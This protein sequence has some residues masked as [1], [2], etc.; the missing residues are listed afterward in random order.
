MTFPW[1]CSSIGQS[2]ALSRRKLRVRVP[3]VPMDTNPKNINWLFLFLFKV[4][5]GSDKERKRNFRLHQ[6]VLFL[7]GMDKRSS[8][9]ILFFSRRWI[10]FI[11]QILLFVILIRFDIIQIKFI[12]LNFVRKISHFYGIKSRSIY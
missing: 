4:R 12:P 11:A 5:K 6:K 9:V 2:T 10:D 7:F 3:S 1:D 8:Y